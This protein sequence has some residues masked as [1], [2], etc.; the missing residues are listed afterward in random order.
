[1]K[2]Q[3]ELEPSA[4][5]HHSPAAPY[6]RPGLRRRLAALRAGLNA[7]MRALRAPNRKH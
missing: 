5:Q 2:Q 7:A 1:M 4:P 6:S 3:P